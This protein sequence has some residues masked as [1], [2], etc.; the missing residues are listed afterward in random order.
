MK[1]FIISFI[2][3]IDNKQTN[4]NIFRKIEAGKLYLAFKKPITKYFQ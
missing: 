1:T 2:F 3:V 4:T